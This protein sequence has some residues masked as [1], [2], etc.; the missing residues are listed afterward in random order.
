MGIVEPQ[1]E[2]H[3]YHD[4]PPPAAV[5]APP[6]PVHVVSSGSSGSSCCMWAVV[7]V[8]VIMICGGLCFVPWN[9][10]GYGHGRSYGYGSGYG[11]GHYGSIYGSPFSSRTTHHHM[12]P[13][14]RVSRPSRLVH[15]H[16][17]G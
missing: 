15:H 13:R 12:A 10:Y 3:V 17:R 4:G 7:V 14:V 16:Y 1:E 8:V 6:A 11:Y 9:S 5:M 2:V